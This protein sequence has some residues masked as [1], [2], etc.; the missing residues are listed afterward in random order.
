MLK[1][2]IDFRA[3]GTDINIQL[4]FRDEKKRS[5]AKNDIGGMVDFYKRFEKVFSRFDL[6]SELS[7]LN[8][9]LGKY[10]KTSRDIINVSREAL[11]YHK[12]SEG[13]FDPRVIGILEN[14]GYHCDFKKADFSNGKIKLKKSPFDSPLKDELKIRGDEILFK[15][16]MDFSGIAKGYITDKAVEFLF[17]LGWENVLVDS[18]GDMRVSGFDFWEKNWKISIEGVDEKKI[19]MELNKENPAIA[20]S[21]ITRR[22][23]ENKNGR[24]HHLINPK[25]P[26]SF[27][28]SLRTVTVVEKNAQEADVWAKILFLTGKEKGLVIS[29]EKNIKSL[30]IDNR[31]NVYISEKMKENISK[32]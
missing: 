18:G 1:E 23:W 21:G 5:R 11:R 25:D 17:D 2:S 10:R 9:N 8:K 19:L 6:N 29:Q 16:R 31:G 20:T 24:F 30:F 4:I 26:C 22:K 15:C 7:V 28:F 13:F 27:D 12:L 3:L 32:P 14:M